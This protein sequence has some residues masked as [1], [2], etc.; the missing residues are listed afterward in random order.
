MSMELQRGLWEKE[1]LELKQK[2]V[3]HDENNFMFLSEEKDDRNGV[4]F[5]KI[6]LI[7]GCDVS[8]SKWKENFACACLVVLNFP[9]LKVVY[10]KI[11]EFELE[12]PYMFVFFILFRVL[13][14]KRVS[15]I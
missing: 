7:G 5:G 6:K 13:V 14:Q 4:D 8:F 11:V 12:L 2:L 9:D 1:Q 10:E 15:R 3:I